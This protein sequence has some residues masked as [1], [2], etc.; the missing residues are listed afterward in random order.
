[1]FKFFLILLVLGVAAIVGSYLSPHAGYLYIHTDTLSIETTLWMGISMIAFLFYFLYGGLELLKNIH[2]IPRKIYQ[3]LQQHRHIQSQHKTHQ[4][5]IEF[6]EGYWQSAQKHLMQGLRSTEIPLLNYLT[7][8][9]S[10]QE[11]NDTQQRDHYLREAQHNEPQAQIAVK[12]TQAQLQIASQQWE[13]ALATLQ[14]LHELRPK[15]PYVIKLLAQLYETVRDWPALCRLLPKIKKYG[16]YSPQQLDELAHRA[17]IPTFERQASQCPSLDQLKQKFNELPKMIQPSP[18]CIAAFA[19]RCAELGDE[20]QAH[21][22]LQ[23]GLSIGL[24]EALLNLYGELPLEEKK[25]QFVQKLLEKHPHHTTLHLLMGQLSLKSRL[26]GQAKLHFEQS[27]AIQPE[28]PKVYEYLGETM[29]ALDCPNE[30][31]HYYKQGL[32]LKNSLH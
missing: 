4:G 20:Q 2:L 31:L 7:A 27:L 17:Y 18:R 8:A 11:L 13:Q 22:M 5:L 3:A 30:A 21:Q 24:D 6:S 1:M 15:H 10:A 25:L 29:E 19:Q 12:L 28:Q 14:H 16:S 26:F 9:R 23:K 32:K